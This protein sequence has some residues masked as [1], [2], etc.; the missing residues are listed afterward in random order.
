MKGAV[1][2]LVWPEPCCDLEYMFFK[3]KIIKEDTSH[4]MRILVENRRTEV[5]QGTIGKLWPKQVKVCRI[6]CK[7]SLRVVTEF[8]ACEIYP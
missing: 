2:P 4:V 7:K 8:I 5:S 6:I 3:E 1:T